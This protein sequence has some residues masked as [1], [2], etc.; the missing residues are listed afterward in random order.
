MI[1][2]ILVASVLVVTGIYLDERKTQRAKSPS[3]SLPD[4]R[5]FNPSHSD[6]AKTPTPREG[7]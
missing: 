6:A 1:T 4:Y 3:K 7:G 2:V 5:I